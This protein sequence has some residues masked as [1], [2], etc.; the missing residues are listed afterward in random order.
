[1]Y[2]KTTQ[3]IFLSVAQISCHYIIL[4]CTDALTNFSVVCWFRNVTFILPPWTIWVIIIPIQWDQHWLRGITMEKCQKKKNNCCSELKI[5]F[6]FLHRGNSW[7]Y[8]NSKQANI[9]ALTLRLMNA[10]SLF[11]FCSYGLMSFR[12]SSV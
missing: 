12:R 3:E 11:S 1:M 9:S 5:C 6:V 2:C 4:N 8:I 7:C 10:R